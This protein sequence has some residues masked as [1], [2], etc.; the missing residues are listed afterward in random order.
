VPFESDVM[1]SSWQESESQ[2]IHARLSGHVSK[3]QT[4]HASRQL[5]ARDKTVPH[6]LYFQT[7]LRL[8]V[9]TTIVQRSTAG[10]YGLL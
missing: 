5:M 1:I 7:Q 10:V 8:N 4:G 6:H 2:L 9:A 3:V